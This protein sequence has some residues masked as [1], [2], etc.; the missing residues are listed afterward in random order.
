MINRIKHIGIKIGID[1][2]I[3]I[4]LVTRLI[5]ATSGILSIFFIARYLSV[6]EQGFFYT[7]ASIIA[8]QVFFE[9]GLSSIITQ[10]AAH[11]FAHLEWDEEWNLV[12]DKY[13]K[14]RLA[15]LLWFCVKCF[16]IISIVLFFSL[17]IIGFWFF[18]KYN[19]DISVNWKNP[20]IILCLATSL[21]L[22]IDP[23]LA[24]FDGIGE[25]KDMSKV[26]LVQKLCNIILLFTFFILGFKLYASALA[27][28]I[29]ILIN[30]FQIGSLKRFKFLKS[31]WKEKHESIINYYQEIFPFQWRIALSWISGYFIFQLF[32]PVLFA[33]EGAKVAGQMGIT[34]AALNGI[35]TL[36]MSWITTKIPMFSALIA[37]KNYNEL[38]YVFDKTIKQLIGINILAI[39]GFV[40]FIYISNYLNLNF[41]N[42]FLYSLPLILLCLTVIANQLVFSWATYLRC[43]KKEPFLVLS[44]VTGILCCISTFFLG[45]NFG[46]NGMVIGYATI[47][48]MCGLVW[49]GFIFK[50]KKL[51]WHK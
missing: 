50:R 6:Y 41:A 4:T 39:G 14:S 45:N 31:I 26:R 48:I 51:E 33:T 32:N 28:L 47:T 10:Y 11:E 30:Y 46:L 44:I 8:I 35:S 24:F 21:N 9:L 42:R 3:A 5:Q 13:Y 2:T 36:S 16:A 15:S 17:L 18:S 7:F 22:F 25:I 34:L 40:F 37:K 38:D 20:W 29:A 27:S 12:G 49:G 19:A 1:R 43:H 23:I